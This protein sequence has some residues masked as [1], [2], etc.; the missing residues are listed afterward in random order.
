MA[1]QFSKLTAF[2]YSVY[3]FISKIYPTFRKQFRSTNKP[4]VGNIAAK[5]QP[6]LITYRRDGAVENRSI[7]CDTVLHMTPLHALPQN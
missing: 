2:Q 1:N 5:Q 7:Q 4:F 3:K 6:T